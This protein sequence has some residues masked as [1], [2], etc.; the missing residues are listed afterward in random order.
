MHRREEDEDRGGASGEGM[1]EK[2]AVSGCEMAERQRACVRLRSRNS[3]VPA[4]ATETA[5]PCHGR[6][7]SGRGTWTTSAASYTDYPTRA[8]ERENVQGE[9]EA[10]QYRVAKM[11][12]IAVSALSLHSKFARTRP[13]HVAPAPASNPQRPYICAL[14]FCHRCIS[15]PSVQRRSSGM[16]PPWNAASHSGMLEL[17]TP[18]TTQ[19]PPFHRSPET[20]NAMLCYRR[21]ASCAKH[22][23]I[24]CY[25]A[26]TGWLASDPRL[27]LLRILSQTPTG[28]LSARPTDGAPANAYE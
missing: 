28:K 20:C 1:K 6:G 7:P 25:V 19:T 11:E 18:R 10:G 21:T 27:F 15:L 13:I 5:T 26:S 3:H 12:T 4:A 8:S 23:D 16:F 17:T 14:L 9:L 24:P 2:K 22:L